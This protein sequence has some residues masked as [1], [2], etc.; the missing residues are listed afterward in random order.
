MVLREEASI[1]LGITKMD[2][3]ADVCRHGF[4]TPYDRSFNFELTLAPAK[5]FRVYRN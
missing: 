4:A 2:D 5:D 3:Y 1:Q